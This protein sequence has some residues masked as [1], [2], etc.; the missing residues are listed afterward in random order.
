MKK[1]QCFFLRTIPLP[2]PKTG[3][4]PAL[5]FMGNGLIAFALFLEISLPSLQ[6]AFYRFLLK[7]KY[8][9]LFLQGLNPLFQL[10]SHAL[11]LF[12]PF[13]KRIFSLFMRNLIPFSRFFHL[14]KLAKLNIKRCLRHVQLVPLP[15]SRIIMRSFLS[16][17]ADR[18]FLQ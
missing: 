4:G 12:L 18:L 13:H 11:S 5:T 7:Q 15:F 16:F 1:K 3:G 9:L 14:S 17:K 8:F 2:Q 6:A 10:F